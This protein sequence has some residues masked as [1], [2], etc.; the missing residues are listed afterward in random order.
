MSQKKNILQYSDISFTYNLK[1]SS[2]TSH[3]ICVDLAHIPTSIRL[4]NI[5]DM[6]SPNFVILF[7][8]HEIK[9]R[10]LIFFSWKL[11]V[12]YLHICM[13]LPKGQLISKCP[14]GVIVW[15]KITNEF[16]STISAL[17][18]K[19]RSNQENKGTLYI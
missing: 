10:I 4:L 15:T 12:V 1:K 5:I 19:K 6:K 7:W 8:V 17:A 3:G 11:F 14:F 9:Q 13:Y 2:F 18:S 16:F